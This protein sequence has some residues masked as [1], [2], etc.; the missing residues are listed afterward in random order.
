MNFDYQTGFLNTRILGATGNLLGL[1]Q[2]FK[3]KINKQIQQQLLTLSGKFKPHLIL[4][5]KG[6]SISPQII[7]Q[8]TRAGIITVNWYPDWLAAWEWIKDNAS[9]YSQ[10]VS[11]C[12]NTNAHLNQLGIN[13]IYL[14][15][16]SAPDPIRYSGQKKYNIVFIGQY[17]KRREHYFQSVSKIGLHIWGYKGWQSSALKHIASGSISNK[18]TLQIIRESKIVLNILTGDDDFQP[19]TVNNRTFESLGVGTFLMIKDH[20]ILYKHFSPRNDFITFKTPEELLRNVKYYLKHDS[21]REK[22]A[23]NGWLNVQKNHTYVVRFQELFSKIS[24]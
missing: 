16:A 6:E 3:P 14:P 9:A 13:S 11:C 12:T 4:V 15:Y 24:L 21:D 20:P 5:V 1:S 2:K 19:S 17:S 22:I 23:E 8:L 10:F 7:R 18:R